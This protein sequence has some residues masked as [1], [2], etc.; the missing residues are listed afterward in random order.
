MIVP[1]TR[2]CL[3]ILHPRGFERAIELT[4]FGLQS[5]EA[6][7]ELGRLLAK[8]RRNRKSFAESLVEHVPWTLPV[9]APNARRQL[10]LL[11]LFA[12][13]REHAP[14]VIEA[15]DPRR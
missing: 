6:P 11:D 2:R 8:Q 4:T 3:P 15:L 1:L 7:V 9:R 14:L 5:E 13:L 10:G 12:P